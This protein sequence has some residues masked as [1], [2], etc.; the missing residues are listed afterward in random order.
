MYETRA[1]VVGNVIS[2]IDDRR[3]SDGTVIASFRVASN[4]RRLDKAT[5]RWIDGNRLIVG[6]TCWRRLAENVHASLVV[7]D[8]VV[9]TGHIYTRTYESQ[10]QVRTVTELEAQ[11]VAPDLSRC[12]A[13]VRRNQRRTDPFA[14]AVEDAGAVPVAGPANQE[15]PADGVPVAGV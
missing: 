4:E 15:A 6:V 7:G 13:V 3:L 10:G 12:T 11:A 14:R 1:T 2:T 5:D 8:P 9:V